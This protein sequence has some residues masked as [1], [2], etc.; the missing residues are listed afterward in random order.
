M[1]LN[2]EVIVHPGE[3]LLSAYIKPSGMSLSEV[4]LKAGVSTASLS[5]LTT[6]KSSMS[7]E[8]AIKM[9][10]VFKRKAKSW[11]LAQVNYDLANLK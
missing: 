6:C 9:E 10:R 4:A 2:K 3:L 5:R 11:L 1:S 8:M 7:A